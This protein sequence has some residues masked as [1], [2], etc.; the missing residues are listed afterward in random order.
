MNTFHDLTA[1]QL[2][3]VIHLKER[4]EY[5]QGL[6]ASL[7]GGSSSPTKKKVGRPTGKRVTQVRR[8]KVKLPVAKKKG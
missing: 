4:I 2:R 5:L 1:A 8:A 6:L 3:H 7:R